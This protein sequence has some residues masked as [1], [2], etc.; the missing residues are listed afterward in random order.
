MAVFRIE[1]VAFPNVSLTETVK[2]VGVRETRKY[3]KEPI[4]AAVLSEK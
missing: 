4:I 3:S 1:S 2:L